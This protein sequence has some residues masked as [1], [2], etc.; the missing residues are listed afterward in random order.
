M[1]L[2]VMIL[3]VNQIAVTFLD[4]THLNYSEG[5]GCDLFWLFFP[6]MLAY[7]SMKYEEL[8]IIIYS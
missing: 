6:I 4:E 5:E 2:F 8:Y 3:Q 1:H 7:C